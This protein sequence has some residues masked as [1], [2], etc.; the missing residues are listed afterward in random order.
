[1]SDQQSFDIYDAL[2]KRLGAEPLTPAEVRRMIENPNH[3]I[4]P[5]A[6]QVI[7]RHMNGSE[8]ERDRFLADQHR[9][10]WDACEKVIRARLSAPIAERRL[11][12][13]HVEAACM[14]PLVEAEDAIRRLKLDVI[15][16]ED[17]ATEAT[18]QRIA[19]QMMAYARFTDEVAKECK[20]H[21]GVKAF[22]SGRRSPPRPSEV[23]A[24]QWESALNEIYKFAEL[25][26]SGSPQVPKPLQHLMSPLRTLAEATG[27]PLK[28]MDLPVKHEIRSTWFADLQ[29]AERLK[30][31]R[32]FLLRFRQDVQNS[33][34][35]DN[36]LRESTIAQIIQAAPD[37]PVLEVRQATLGYLHHLVVESKKPA[38]S[39]K[40]VLA[41]VA[42]DWGRIAR[43]GPPTGIPHRHEPDPR[44]E[45]PRH[46]P[47]E[48]KPQPEPEPEPDGLGGQALPDRP[49]ADPKRQ[50]SERPR[51]ADSN[52]RSD[53][54]PDRSR[55]SDPR[56]DPDRSPASNP[57]MP[58]VVLVIIVVAMAAGGITLLSS[59]YKPPPPPSWQS[60]PASEFPKVEA[61]VMSD[62]SKARASGVVETAA[63][64]DQLKR[65]L[66][67]N[68]RSVDTGAVVIQPPDHIKLARDEIETSLGSRRLTAVLTMSTASD[69]LPV[70]ELRAPNRDP[71]ALEVLR[72][73]AADVLSRHFPTEPAPRLVVTGPPIAWIGMAEAPTNGVT[74]QIAEDKSAA[75]AQGVVY[76][77]RE[78]DLLRTR[79]GHPKV[80]VDVD[81]VDVRPKE[82]LATIESAYSLVLGN[83]PQV[84]EIE[85]GRI[86]I[87]G[88]RPLTTEEATSIAAR[89]H[90]ILLDPLIVVYSVRPE[91]VWE[92]SRVTLGMLMVEEL[93][94][95]SKVRA[96]GKVLSDHEKAQAIRLLKEKITE[97]TELQAD[98]IAIDVAAVEAAVRKD[99]QAS[100]G[101]D[102][103]VDNVAYRN[104]DS[105]AYLHV[106]ITLK[107]KGR[108]VQERQRVED[109]ARQ[110]A[111]SSLF[112]VATSMEVE[113]YFPPP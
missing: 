99:V 67:E 44:R 8:T 51:G 41:I 89:V 66:G 56:P 52:R 86:S 94:D 39:A 71:A 87:V 12:R 22:L 106:E 68:A 91:P 15:P 34:V 62:G 53:T 113:V 79:L 107:A 103:T 18:D 10:R 28:S 29:R 100:V 92:K 69:G 112:D 90:R 83:R 72:Q 76:S 32:D 102:A 36:L 17:L 80:A 38:G 96:I 70:F 4:D 24:D 54:P 58:R 19:R 40:D 49:A 85:N 74:V 27:F 104:R 42:A 2:T 55:Q 82:V 20:S 35:P 108:S 73:L 16:E 21:D 61:F 43:D 5:A 111:S 57:R 98:G 13:S 93:S 14:E 88:P 48:P 81:R 33:I 25:A 11:R 37:V 105:R 30:P 84:S 63:Q 97:G 78:R 31:V 46:G 45:Q 6:R 65:I 23:T 47:P 26:E 60:F 109:L 64:L 95:Q 50:Q 75:T 110:A 101:G 77:E 1:M 59:L 9:L 7:Q 3:K